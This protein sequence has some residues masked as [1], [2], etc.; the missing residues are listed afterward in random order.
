MPVD[1]RAPEPLARV[2]CYAPARLVQAVADEVR[3][4]QRSGDGGRMELALEMAASLP[5]DYART[6]SVR[7]LVDAAQ[8]WLEMHR[9]RKLEYRVPEVVRE[10]LE[11]LLS[12]LNAAGL[13]NDRQRRRY[14]MTDLLIAMTLTV[15]DP[16]SPPLGLDQEGRAKLDRL[17]G[18]A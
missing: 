16:D 15:V 10:H 11:N 4:R 13:P 1:D 9:A 8:P 2:S 17:L 14:D 12:H 7:A 3:R 5:R 18:L 6:E